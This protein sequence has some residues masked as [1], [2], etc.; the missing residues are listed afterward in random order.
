LEVLAE[1]VSL[2]KVAPD[3]RLDLGRLTLLNEFEGGRDITKV[4][5]AHCFIT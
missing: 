2:T 1:G 4:A 5:E 3:N